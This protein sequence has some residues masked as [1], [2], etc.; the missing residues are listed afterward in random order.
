[1]PAGSS[2]RMLLQFEDDVLAGVKIPCFAIRGAG[3]GPALAITACIH[4]G[5]YPGPAAAIRL[6]RAIDPGSL[7]GSLVIVPIANPSS[8]RDRTAFVTP[9]DGKNLNRVFPGDPNGTFSEVLAYRLFEHITSPADML[10][11]LHSGDIFETLRHYT[12]Y[13]AAPD[14]RVREQSELVAR[15][16]DTPIL[17]EDRQPEPPG[18]SN[19]SAV[20]AI[21]KPV[22]FVEIGSNGL[23]PQQDEDDV[24][25]GLINSLKALKMIP[26]TPEPTRQQKHH[27]S[28]SVTSPCTGLWRP[29]VQPGETVS[30]GDLLGRLTDAFGDELATVT[31]PA[32]GAV[33]YFMSALSV[34]EG[35]LLVALSRPADPD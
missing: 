10:I 13:Y 19:T 15:S 3:D 9:E 11:D 1:M 5:E 34:R 24:F 27:P 18:R 29:M 20:A 12:G 30:R 21:G 28:G 16:F 4:G 22:V 7:S 6:A 31:S 32:D 35:E 14:L 25:H 17:L 26:G 33:L 2:E 8:F 23:L